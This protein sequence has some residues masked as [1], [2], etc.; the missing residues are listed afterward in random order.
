MFAPRRF[1]FSLP[2]SGRA[3][4]CLC[5][6]Y[7]LAGLTGHDPWKTD[8]ALNFGITYTALADGRWL[9]PHLAG[10]NLFHTPPLYHWLA[11]AC[12]WIFAGLLP[13][14]DAVRLATGIFAAAFLAFLVLAGRRLHGREAG[15][16]AALVAI[17]CLG[18]LVP[19]HE[20]QPQIALLAACAA[21]YAGLARMPLQPLAGGTEAGLALGTA[22]LAGGAPALLYLLPLPLLL[23]AHGDWRRAG[24]LRAFALLLLLA[25]SCAALWPL[26]LYSQHPAALAA[27]WSQFGLQVQSKAWAWLP[28][29]AELL[30]WFAWPALPLAAWSIWLQRRELMAAKPFLLLLGSGTS[31]LVL[32]LFFEPRPLAALP[33]LVPLILLATSAAGQLRRGAANAFDWFGM[34]TFTLVAGL[35]WLGG[36]AL[37][38]G[39]PPRVANNFARLQPGFVGQG[40]AV[41][42]GLAFLFSLAWIGM[43]VAHP[44]SPWRALTHW[45]AGVTLAWVLAVI[46]MLPWVDY[47][48]SYRTVAVSLKR[49]L[50]LPHQC[51]AERRLGTSQRISLDYFAGI[52]TRRGAAAA[53]CDLLLEQGGGGTMP[54]GWEMIWEG[55]R[56][57]DRSERLR[58]YRRGY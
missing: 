43:I 27:W 10:E 52:K 50:P 37:D 36:F 40:T 14:H 18:L 20:T 1:S 32:L 53:A 4:A 48:K 19:M 11:A 57:G 25:T 26:L 47:G 15:D 58:L 24:R 33:L 54:T 6:I 5:L 29:Q 30:S 16:A 13:T 38:M 56:P 39:L 7:V 41:A 49:A 12:A 45:A 31:L 35:L 44:R 34:M 22:F 17:G 51:I 21:F 46:F 8:D 42:W 3:L 55:S 2:L 23:P 28:A 9:L